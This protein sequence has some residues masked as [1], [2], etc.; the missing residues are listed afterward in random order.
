MSL[1]DNEDSKD[2][3]SQYVYRAVDFLMA[4]NARGTSI[5]IVVGVILYGVRD[6]L[7]YINE[8][9]KLVKWY[10]YIFFGIFSGNVPKLISKHDY[11]DEVEEALHYVKK[12]Q[13]EGNFSEAEKRMQYRNLIVIVQEKCL[14][15]KE[16]DGDKLIPE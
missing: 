2:K 16:N 12:I 14:N 11:N 5:G 9:F 1:L 10:A 15:N 4:N 7:A 13:K 3:V 8:A 6:V